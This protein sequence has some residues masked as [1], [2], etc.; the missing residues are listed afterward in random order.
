MWVYSFLSSFD[1]LLISLLQTKEHPTSSSLS[2]S[3]P[4]ST[5]FRARIL[6]DSQ[7]VSNILLNRADFI[8]II[9]GPNISVHIC[10]RKVADV[11]K[12]RKFF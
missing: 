10:V 4:L 11:E 7:I 3:T 2:I 6:E 5:T 12:R 9:H 1:P 8:Q